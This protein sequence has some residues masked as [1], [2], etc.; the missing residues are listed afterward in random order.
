MRVEFDIEPA[1]AA[2]VVVALED[3]V[4]QMK[5]RKATA[6]QQVAVKCVADGAVKLEV[7]FESAFNASDDGRPLSELM[8]ICQG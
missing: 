3:S 2:G 4:R 7:A 8:S 1:E 6:K 5:R